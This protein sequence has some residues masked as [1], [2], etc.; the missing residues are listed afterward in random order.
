MC[1]KREGEGQQAGC[2]RR[3]WFGQWG[4]RPVSPAY[5]WYMVSASE[6]WSTDMSSC[7]CALVC[8]P[9]VGSLWDAGGTQPPPVAA[10]SSGSTHLPCVWLLC[11]VACTSPAQCISGL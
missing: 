9:A 4:W 3:F 11:Y 2:S 5:S 8:V 7:E 6:T 10:W 1:W